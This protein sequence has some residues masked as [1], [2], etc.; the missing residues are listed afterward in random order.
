MSNDVKTKND[1]EIRLFFSA[2]DRMMKGIDAL[3]KK[4]RPL[5]GGHRYLTAGELHPSGNDGL[6]IR[7][8]SFSLGHL[9][10]SSY[11]RRH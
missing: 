3:R 5:L 1:E 6:P 7:G 2:G 4:N 11:G 10:R 9:S 8:C